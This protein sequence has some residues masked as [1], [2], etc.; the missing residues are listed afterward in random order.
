MD[1]QSQIVRNAE[2]TLDLL[3]KAITKRR[4]YVRR[5]LSKIQQKGREQQPKY[6]R[7]LRGGMLS[8]LSTITSV[9][10]QIQSGKIHPDELWNPEDDQKTERSKN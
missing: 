9:L 7:A 5:Q 10:K 6:E 4:D 8:E 1:D 3:E 2:E